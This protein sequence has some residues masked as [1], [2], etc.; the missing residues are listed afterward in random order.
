MRKIGKSKTVRGFTE[1]G[2]VGAVTTVLVG[3]TVHGVP[4]LAEYRGE[5]C[6][7]YGCMA[8]AVVRE[9][10]ARFLWRSMDE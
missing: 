1:G 6:V 7:I 2:F 4:F 9:V 8:G 5:L 3:L 10:L